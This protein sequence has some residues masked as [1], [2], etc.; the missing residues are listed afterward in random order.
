MAASRDLGAHA[1]RLYL[2]IAANRDGY[3]LALSPAAL[4]TSIGMARSTYHDQFHILVDKGYLVPTSG[5]KY[6]FF[7]KSQPRSG[8]NEKKSMLTGGLNFENNP[9]TDIPILKAEQDIP[10]K[11]IEINNIDNT[12]NSKINIDFPSKSK[13]IKKP[14][15]PKVEYITIKDPTARRSPE[16]LRPLNRYGIH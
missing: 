12:I 7:E 16:K 4:R 3:E 5:N 9:T 2:Y 8:I 1:L 11:D 10:P 14:F 13:E 6:E 15:E